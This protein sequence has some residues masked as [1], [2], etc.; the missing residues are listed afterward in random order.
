MYQMALFV[1]EYVVIFTKHAMDY[2]VIYKLR[3]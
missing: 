3:A 2:N 1:S